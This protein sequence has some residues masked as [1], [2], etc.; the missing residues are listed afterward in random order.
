MEWL[1][2][3]GKRPHKSNGVCL[4]SYL[5][6]VWITKTSLPRTDSWIC[7]RVSMETN[8]TC[9]IFARD[10]AEGQAPAVSLSQSGRRLSRETTTIRNT[11]LGF[12]PFHRTSFSSGFKPALLV[13][14]L[15]KQTRVS[16]LIAA[17]LWSEHSRLSLQAMLIS[18]LL[19]RVCGKYIPSRT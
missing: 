8:K 7:T 16:I 17:E 11:R 13:A 6:M 2:F 10:K 14:T 9:K 15:K 18:S 5:D 4:P 1:V 3:V 19:R 12:E